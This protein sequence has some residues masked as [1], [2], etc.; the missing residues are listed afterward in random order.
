M[1]RNE[2]ADII[3]HVGRLRVAFLFVNSLTQPIT[4]SLEIWKLKKNKG[5]GM[6]PSVEGVFWKGVSVWQMGMDNK[7]V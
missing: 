5:S 2:R 6:T 4:F 1:Q 7:H 3:G